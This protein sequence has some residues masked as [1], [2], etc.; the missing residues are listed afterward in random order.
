MKKNHKIFIITI[1]IKTFNNQN[2]QTLITRCYLYSCYRLR[3]KNEKN[4]GFKF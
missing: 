2:A 3:C 1:I 4:D